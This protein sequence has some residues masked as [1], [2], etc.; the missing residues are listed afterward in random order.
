MRTGLTTL[1]SN[2]K[3]KFPLDSSFYLFGI[4]VI[5]LSTLHLELSKSS[6]EFFVQFIVL[7]LILTLILVFAGFGMIKLANN[8]G[9]YVL[10]YPKMVLASFCLL[11]SGAVIVRLIG[12]LYNIPIQAPL[13]HFFAVMNLSICWLPLIVISGGFR[14]RLLESFSHYEQRLLI[15][16]R[17][18]IRGTEAYKNIQLDIDRKIRQELTFYSNKLLHEIETIDTCKL[19]ITEA[20]L[21]L[22]E[23]LIG[24]DLRNLSMKLEE[25]GQ[26][27]IKRQYFGQDIHAVSL[28]AG[29]FRLLYS[30]ISQIAPFKWWVYLTSMMIMVT[31]GYINYFSWDQ[32]LI[33]Y[34]SFMLSTLIV[35][36]L[37]YRVRPKAANSSTRKSSLGILFLAYL[38]LIQNQ[39]AI[40]VEPDKAIRFPFFVLAITLPIFYFF[41]IRTLQIL[42]PSAIDLIA[43]DRLEASP[44]LKKSVT[45][46][47]TQ[48]FEHTFAHRWAIYIHGK[49]LTRLAATAL[50]IQTA[51]DNNDV[52]GF[53]KA[54]AELIEL[55]KSP[56]VSF[57]I[58]SPSLALEIDSRLDP[59]QGLLNIS[60][61]LSP[62]L[63]EL[64]GERVR[65]LG[66]VLEEA[67]ANSSRHGHSKN[68]ILRVIRANDK[69][70]E[71][72]LTD[73][74][75]AAPEDSPERNGLGTQIF[76][77]VSDGRWSLTRLESGTEFKLRMLIQD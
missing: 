32:T 44:A 14:T 53:G 16:T 67:I 22:Q 4:L 50:R 39:I 68:L 28:L 5:E 71:I 27:P 13:A 3:R 12:S 64:T 7:R 18:K 6:H 74:A 57:E 19:E 37:I 77:L 42:Q 59:W 31:P 11:G 40:R 73:D 24:N 26:T 69:E 60:Y 36:L 54:I 30:A 38:P 45:G 49:I 65:E 8:L 9:V 23:K 33:F 51:T 61:E 63:E 35:S 66:E 34:P 15:A 43:T 58:T 52:K 56:D 70:I 76:N 46:V 29:Q 47:V 21:L 48:E 41:F 2:L 55:L 17:S 25:F 10:T 1:K 62:G 20:N 72:R 75:G